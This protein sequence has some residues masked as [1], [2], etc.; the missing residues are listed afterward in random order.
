MKSVRSALEASLGLKFEQDKGEHFFRSTLVQTIFYGLFS[1]WVLWSKKPSHTESDVFNWHDALWELK[2]P[3]MQALFGQIV[4][5]AHIGPLEFEDILNWAAATLN[6]VDSA[7][8]FSAFEEDK[9]VQYFYEPFLEAFDPELRKQLGVWYTPPE[10]VQ[11]MVSRVDTVLREELNI[12]DGLA[13]PNVFVLD[14]CCG[15]G[16]Y[17]VEVIRHIHQ[18]LKSKGSD[19]LLASDLKQAALKRVFGFE[20][21]PAPFVVSHMQLGLILQKL[22]ATLSDTNNERTGVYLTNALTGWEPLDPEKEKAFQAMLTGFPQL[23]DEQTDARKVKQQVP[24]LVILG[25]PPYNAFSGT[26][27]TKEE[28]ESIAPSRKGL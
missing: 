7:S 10:I 1:A 23:L 27:T 6:R 2:V 3:V 17:L 28:R 5:P 8:F 20:I 12:S 9:A 16:S 21:L 18:T 13:D 15:T 19:A 24:I 14:P 4:T 25:N 26:A 11:Y 22:G